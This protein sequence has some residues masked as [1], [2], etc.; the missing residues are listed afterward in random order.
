MEEN[1][2]KYKLAGKVGVGAAY[3]VHE[4]VKMFAEAEY[5][6]ISKAKFKAVDLKTS[7]M[8]VKIGARYYF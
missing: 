8:A 5:T 4:N 7:N 3:K 6:M 1:K 2:T